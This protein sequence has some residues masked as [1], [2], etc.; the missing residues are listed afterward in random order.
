MRKL[1]SAISRRKNERPR[2]TTAEE[3]GAEMIGHGPMPKPWDWPGSRWWR[4]DLHAH[5]PAS[6]DFKENRNDPD[7]GQWVAALGDRNIDAVAVTDHN[8]ADGI[9][10]LQEAA[11]DSSLVL[12]PGV[13]VTVG[14]VHLLVIL[15]PS[16][17]KDHVTDILTRLEVPVSERGHCNARSPLSIE[18]VLAECGASPV[19]IGAH[20]NGPA[21]LLGLKGE[22]RLAVLRNPRLAAVE[23]DP[24]KKVDDRWIDGEMSVLRRRLARVWASDAH[25][26]DELGRRYTW[27]KMTTLSSEGLRL[28]LG[29]GSYADGSR[30]L[31]PWTEANPNKRFASDVVESITVADARH[32]GRPNS[33]EFRFNP[34]FNAIIGGRGTGKST[35]VDFCRQTLR[36]AAELP[37]SL[38]DSFDRRLS[39]SHSRDGEGLLTPNTHITMV[40][41]KDGERYRL[42]W[43][44]HGNIHP[45]V[46]LKDDEKEQGNIARRFPVRL[47][48]QKQL[49]EIAQ[50][51]NA[52]LDVIDDSQQVGGAE[53][54]RLMEEAAARYLACRSQARLARQQ[55]AVLPE[56]S[57]R[58]SD[59][60]R[61]LDV[62]QKADSANIL[63]QHRG[64]QRRQD[65]WDA[66]LE[67]VRDAI[68][69]VRNATDDLQ[70][71]DLGIDMGNT[72][73]GHET[74][75]ER[76]HSSLID[77]IASLRRRIHASLESADSDIERIR[78]GPAA[79]RWKKVVLRDRH[80]FKAALKNLSDQGIGGFE[81]YQEL[82]AEAAKLERGIKYATQRNTRSA[83]REEQAD[84]AL[85]EYR[86]LRET[87]AKRRRA[88]VVKASSD[89][90]KI[91]VKALDDHHNLPSTL[92]KRLHTKKFETDRQAIY[93]QLHT[94][95][96]QPWHWNRLDNMVM[97]LR[98]SRNNMPKGW[99]SRDKRFD[100]VLRKIDPEDVDRLALYA[101]GDSVLVE[102]RD[103]SGNWKKLAQ[104]SPGQQ[105]A[106]LLAFVLRQGEEPIILDQPEDDLDNTVIYELLV[107]TLRQVKTKRQVIVVTHNPNIVVHGDAE[108]VLSLGAVNGQT[109]V[110][111]KGGLQ[112]QKVRE[113]ICRVMEGGEEAFRKRYHRIVPPQDESP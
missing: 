97:T 45:V 43:N 37:T 7:W 16:R 49:F 56:L 8:T 57:I 46:R 82:L 3:S 38:R 35:L 72:R 81:D 39:V 83:N 111:C 47:Y 78:T 73:D 79:A 48:S 68:S 108:Y 103:A 99:R 110:V 92:E 104:G 55:A 18:Q 69:L 96:N 25:G 88:Y 75:L 15:D 102:Y 42:S 20:V 98:R 65:V 54:H 44:P 4:V 106:A 63:A 76:M 62:L 93:G 24:N 91:R 32:I 80:R 19:V 30:S 66:V 23:I 2:T 77:A 22:S 14:D 85:T 26:F 94:D 27:I 60:R 53:L 86:S 113:E 67:S 28:A 17:R 13:E 12:F 1:I 31:R 41:R 90:V 112:D 107:T 101:P 59:V 11:Q 52:L 10:P 9:T 21:G 51:P 40:Y 50:N 29:D 61:K 109:H 5:S 74:D 34:W 105:A 87:L 71:A 36:R 58:L 6:H 100:K 84:E 95:S 33:V 70:V 64:N 89:S